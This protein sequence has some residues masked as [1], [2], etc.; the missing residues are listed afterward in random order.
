[1][2]AHAL[3]AQIL[4]PEDVILNL[5]VA[6][7]HAR[8]VAFLLDGAF[9]TLVVVLLVL[10]LLEFYPLAF[11]DYPHLPTQEEKL[12]VTALKFV[13][14]MMT[15][16]Y[17][18]FFEVKWSGQTPGKRLL[19][20]RVTMQDGSTLET[21]SI[22]A[23][24]LTRDLETIFPIAALLSPASLGLEGGFQIVLFLVWLIAL[25]C[26]PL[27]NSHHY[28]LGDLIAKTMV[29]RLPRAELLA[30]LSGTQPANGA[31]GKEDDGTKDHGLRFTREQLSHYGAEELHVLE[32]VLRFHDDDASPGGAL[33]TNVAGRIATRTGWTT[34]NEALAT[35]LS[36]QTFAQEFL[37][38]FYRAQRAHLEELLRRGGRTG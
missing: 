5:K 17:F 27:M 10:V 20:L 15:K 9:M 29:I 13:G 33:V 26:I 3:D 23:R 37:T 30:D 32:D 1:M 22:V 31:D 21:G 12:A 6:P 34:A 38:A 28:R 11:T 14:F 35:R 25:S 2:S 7:W 36:D 24:N 18:I 19:G 16:F 8:L 4:T